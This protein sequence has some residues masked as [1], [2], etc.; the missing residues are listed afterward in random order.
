MIKAYRIS[1]LLV[2][3][4]YITSADQAQ[5]HLY[6]ELVHYLRLIFSRKSK[7]PVEKVKMRGEIK[8]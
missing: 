5:I 3:Y 6:P 7:Q 8:H 4:G 2:Y 1:M